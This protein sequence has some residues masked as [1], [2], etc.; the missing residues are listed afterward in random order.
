MYWPQGSRLPG[1]RVA[2]MLDGNRIDELRVR[3]D[4]LVRL[5][6]KGEW[7]P[8]DE[9]EYTALADDEARYIAIRDGLSAD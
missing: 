3:L 1:R 2:D 4:A 5:R 6:T 9:G 7:T 8:E